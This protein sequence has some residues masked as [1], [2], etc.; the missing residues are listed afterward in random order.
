LEIIY[1]YVDEV[2]CE[3]SETNAPPK[4]QL[5]LSLGDHREIEMSP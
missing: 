3:D 4:R 1:Q 2:I 5:T